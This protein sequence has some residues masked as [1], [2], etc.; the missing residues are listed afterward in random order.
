VSSGPHQPE[1]DY[2]AEFNRRMAELTSQLTKANRRGVK[3]IRA[4]VKAT[5]GDAVNETR[6]S[7]EGVK[8][9]IS[10][11]KTD[12]EKILTLINGNHEFPGIV[13]RLALAEERITVNSK[14][15][16]WAITGLVVLL[17][18]VIAE[19]IHIITTIG[20]KT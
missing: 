14:W 13:G 9:D 17:L 10:G 16:Y 4:D 6:R 11:I 2:S 1:T 18:S 8:S 12:V 5:I 20:I 3:S 15:I 19:A 7:V